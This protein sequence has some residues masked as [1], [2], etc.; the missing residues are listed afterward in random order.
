MGEKVLL[1]I[2]GL[3]GTLESSWEG[4]CIVKDKLSRVNYRITDL[5]VRNRRVIHINNSKKYEPR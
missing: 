2:P 1:Q 3:R 4:S 5:E